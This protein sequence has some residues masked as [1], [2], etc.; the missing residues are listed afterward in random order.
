MGIFNDEVEKHREFA[1]QIAKQIIERIG[2]DEEGLMMVPAIIS[3]I[4]KSPF[5]E[6]SEEVRCEF[7]SL[8]E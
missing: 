3:R 6:P 4:D 2:F 7:L 5:P 1:I 8:L